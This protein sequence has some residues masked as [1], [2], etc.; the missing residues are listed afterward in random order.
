MA[1]DVAATQACE[2]LADAIGLA[3]VRDASRLTELVDVVT[4]YRI[5]VVASGALRDKAKAIEW[6]G[7]RMADYAFTIP[8]GPPCRRLFADLVV[9]DAFLPLD[10][11]CL[12]RAKKFASAGFS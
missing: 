5:L 11:K 4:G 8:K 1:A 7:G 6:M 9:L 12:G 2:S 10:G 3:L